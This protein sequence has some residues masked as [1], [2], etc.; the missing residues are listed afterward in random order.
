MCRLM[1]Q[2]RASY[3]KKVHYQRLA[4]EAR[5]KWL[6]MGHD[7]F[8]ES[9]MLRVQPTS[10]LGALELETLENMTK[11][12]HRHQMFVRGDDADTR[13]AEAEGWGAK[14]LDFEDPQSETKET[15]A[16]VLDTT[17]GFIKCSEACLYY[18]N[19]A[20]A[21]GVDFVFGL[22][23]GA[24]GRLVKDEA[25]QAVALKTKDGKEHP[26]DVTVIAGE[27]SYRLLQH[28]TSTH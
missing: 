27:R 24:F 21:L 25:G 13:R 17:A 28:L 14:L 12:G 20:K 8:V 22:E 18:Y 3:G 5:A 23:A 6:E 4:M 26:A 19:L 16:A 7:L 9:G 15:F 2:F 11:E 1:A 10:E